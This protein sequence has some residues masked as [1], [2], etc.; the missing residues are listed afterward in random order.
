MLERAP[1]RLDCIGVGA[2]DRALQALPVVERE[3][4]VDRQPARRAVV[5]APGKLDGEFHRL[6]GTRTRDDVLRVLAG[7]QHV[8]EQRTELH[9]APCAARLDVGQYALQVA[10]TRGERLHFAKSLVDLL[11]ALG[12]LL[13]RCTE[14]LLER[15]LQLLIHGRAH[16]LELLRVIGTQQVEALLER[17]AKR[18]ESGFRCLRQLR[19]PFTE[20]LEL[21]RLRVRGST[22]QLCVGLRVARHEFADFLAQRRSRA[23]RFIAG[24]CE[25]LAYVALVVRD[26]ATDRFQP[27]AQFRGIACS[28]VA[29]ARKSDQ[30]HQR[31]RREHEQEN[32]ADNRRDQPRVIHHERV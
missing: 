5:A 7:R 32:E 3:L 18:I 12:H 4:G 25:I 14:P 17:P 9:L 22:V 1:A 30:P 13:E 8:G 21:G 19:Q 11:E 16:L 6:P 26:A 31:R 15:R 2:L 24:D 28:G 10:D 20:R 27:A 23:R 29:L